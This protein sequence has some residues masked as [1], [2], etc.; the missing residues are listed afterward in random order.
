MSFK[1]VG[2]PFEPF[3]ELFALTC[4]A[5][6]AR[7]AR[8]VFATEKPG[9]PCRVSLADAEIGE[10]LLLLPFTHQPAQS[11]YRASGPIFVRKAARLCELAAGVVP[12]YVRLRQ[13]SLRAYDAAHSMIDAAVCE[14]REVAPAIRAMFGNSAV[15]YIHLHNAKRGCYSCRADRA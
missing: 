11:P 5:L 3:A 2:V 10:E 4:E 8:R 14:G 6:A 9:Y 7:G 15:A 13:M 12:D 1:L